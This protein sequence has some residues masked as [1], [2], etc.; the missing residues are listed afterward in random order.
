MW[1]LLGSLCIGI[2]LI[3]VGLAV[4]Y[5]VW[6]M[7]QEAAREEKLKRRG[8]VVK[9][10]IVF[11]NDNLYKK[12]A[13]DNFW[14]AQVVF[15]LVEDVRNLDDVL[16]DLAEEIREFETEDEEDDDERIIGQ[17]VRTEYGYSWPLRIP[18]RITG[19]L[20][21]YTSTVDVQCKWLP[22]RRLEEPYIY[23][24]A[25]VGKDRQDRLAR[26]V[27]YPDDDD[28]EDYE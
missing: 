26:M 25:Y 21:A 12:N 15:T 1:W 28:D 7:R 17:V 13:R 24:K 27:P 19:R 6:F 5:Y 9:A 22:A 18:K 2:P 4:G 23:I 20:V 3:L 14:P 11:A 8:R 10:W 16:E